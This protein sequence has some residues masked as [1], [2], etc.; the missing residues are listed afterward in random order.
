M[1]QFLQGVGFIWQDAQ[2]S[3]PD[4]LCYPMTSSL[5]PLRMVLLH[6]GHARALTDFSCFPP[7][8]ATGGIGHIQPLIPASLLPSFNI[9]PKGTTEGEQTIVSH[10]VTTPVPVTTIITALFNQSFK[11]GTSDGN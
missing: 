11:W 3:H 4:R 10:R 8:P 7:G 5:Q 9:W 6:L 1:R 2:P